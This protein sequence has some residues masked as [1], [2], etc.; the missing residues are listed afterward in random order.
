MRAWVSSANGG[1]RRSEWSYVCS[2][3]LERHVLN[4]RQ[5]SKAGLSHLYDKDLQRAGK[6]EMY[7]SSDVCMHAHRQNNDCNKQQRTTCLAADDDGA[8]IGELERR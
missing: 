1:K 8:L 6:I 4:R 7:G 3:R 2:T 5:R